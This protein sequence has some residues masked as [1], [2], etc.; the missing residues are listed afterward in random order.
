MLSHLRQKSRGAISFP[1]I[2]VPRRY[3]IGT[4]L[5]AAFVAMSLITAGLGAYGL[6]FLSEAGK[7]VAHTYDG[8]L[9]AINFARSAS[10]QFMQMEKERLRRGMAAEA[11]KPEI[12]KKIDQLTADFYQDLGVAEERSLGIKERRTIAQIKQLVGEWSNARRAGGATPAADGTI[13]AI[14]DKIVD[15]FDTLIELTADDSFVERRRAVSALSDFTDMSYLMSL[16][17]LLLSAVI[18]FILARRIVKPLAAA[19]NVADRIAAGDL[20]TPIPRGGKDET[21]ALLGSMAVMQG[22]LSRMMETETGLRQM[23]QDKNLELDRAVA[24]LRVAKEAAETANLAKSRFL[25]TMSHEIRTP[26]NGVLGMASLLNRTSLD[27][28]QARYLDNLRRSGGALLGIINDVLDLSKIEA[29]GLVLDEIAFDPR[30]LIAE[31]SDLF[32]ERCSAKGL[33][34]IYSVAD[35]VPY[36]LVGDQARLRQVLTNFVGNSVKFTDRGE[37]SI[38]LDVAKAEAGQTTLRF[39]VIDTGIGIAPEDQP[40]VFESFRQVDSSPARRHGGTGLGLAIAKQLAELMDGEI[41]VESTYGQGSRFW[42]TAR[43]TN[44]AEPAPALPRVP[45]GYRVLLVDTNLASSRIMVRHMAGWGIDVESAMTR[46]AALAQIRAA[47]SDRFDA[48]I[49]D[50]KG[51]GAEGLALLGEVSAL[52]RLTPEKIILLTG[53]EGLPEG[54]LDGITIFASLTK[55]ARPAILLECLAAPAKDGGAV[56][57]SIVGPETRRLRPGF[58]ARVLV[59]EDNEVNQEVAIGTLEA[60]GCRVTTVSGGQDAIHLLLRED[61]DIVLLDCEMPD[62]DGFETT[63]QIRALEAAGGRGARAPAVIVAL[64][65]HVLAGTRERCLEAGMNDYMGKPYTEEQIAGILE[66]WLPEDRRVGIAAEPRGQTPAR[67]AF[68][69]HDEIDMTAIEAIRALA[70]PGGPDLLGRVVG[71]F[72]EIAPGIVST[73][74]DGVARRDSGAV[75]TAAH[76]LKASAANLGLTRIAAYAREIESLSSANRLE[77]VEPLIPALEGAMAAAERG[78]GEMMATP[79]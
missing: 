57:R 40:E 37:I 28:R 14:G 6:Y 20:Q 64:T 32:I 24:E 5:F 26:M 25:A 10:L 49:L 44:S 56:A 12:D 45:D 55:P 62:M 60:M 42:F 61:F 39:A 23:A 27:E 47:G 65:A 36:R 7:I 11:Q 38:E 70:R 71:K 43:L 76:S 46:A 9:M 74:K 19:A 59:V 3:S 21:G 13:D 66:R 75:R 41:G 30:E 77:P 31:I 54:T 73:I 48:L 69:G 79:P 4:K 1:V 78:L 51:L 58:S 16:L 50:V 72:I 33:E 63:R 29:G 18:T 15:R 34:L 68:S 67:R 17:A 35:D 52:P 8:P 53:Y 2:S 22:N